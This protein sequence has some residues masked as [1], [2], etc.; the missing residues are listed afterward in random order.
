[1]GFLRDESY[2]SLLAK[3]SFFIFELGLTTGEVT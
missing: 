3:S 1:M 2:Y